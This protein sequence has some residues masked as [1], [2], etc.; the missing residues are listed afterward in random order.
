MPD[1]TL[2][3][4]E[5]LSTSMVGI[6]PRSRWS[7]RDD[8]SYLEKRDDHELYSI[9]SRSLKSNKKNRKNGSNYSITKKYAGSKIF[10]ISQLF[11]IS[12]LIIFFSGLNNSSSDFTSLSFI[13]INWKSGSGVL[14]L[15]LS[16]G[17][18]YFFL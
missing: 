10:L 8:S 9:K 5:I 7:N 14:I 6:R 13:G 2:Y 1:K 18:M 4:E 17:L 12:F 3:M 16:V 11:G 15:L